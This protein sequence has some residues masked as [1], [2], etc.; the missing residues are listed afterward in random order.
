MTPAPKF[1]RKESPPQNQAPH[2]RSALTLFERRREREL[3]LSVT[4]AREL[5]Y[6]NGGLWRGERAL[7][8]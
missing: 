8:C 6:S 1:F 3:S 4:S 2:L 5:P 7:Y